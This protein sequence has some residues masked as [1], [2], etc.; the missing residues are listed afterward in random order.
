MALF[1]VGS[2]CTPSSSSLLDLWVSSLQEHVE[3]TTSDF[4]H[5]CTSTLLLAASYMHQ[6]RDSD[7]GHCPNEFQRESSHY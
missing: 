2:R 1:W 5:Q 6:L 7:C 3:Q 4:W